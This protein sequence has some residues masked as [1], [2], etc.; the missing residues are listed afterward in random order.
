ML[1]ALGTN[2]AATLRR[3][4]RAAANTRAGQVKPGYW[5]R[6]ARL[7]LALAHKRGVSGGGRAVQKRGSASKAP[8]QRRR[9]K[10][11]AHVGS[12]LLRVC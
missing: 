5:R 3:R 9:R 11:C 1:V 8:L 12:Q 2:V 10:R 6:G 4:G 7:R